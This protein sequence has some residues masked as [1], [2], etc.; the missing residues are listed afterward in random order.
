M[1]IMKNKIE[2]KAGIKIDVVLHRGHTIPAPP[3]TRK[4]KYDTCKPLEKYFGEN[5]GGPGLQRIILVD[6]K[7]CAKM[8]A[9]KIY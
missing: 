2:A 3:E 5:V 1:E 9:F 4:R 8:W 7:V 6:D